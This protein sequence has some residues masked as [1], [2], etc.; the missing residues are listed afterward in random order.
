ML[1]LIWIVLKSTSFQF[2]SFKYFLLN[3]PINLNIFLSHSREGN[4]LLTFK[5]KP[6][7]VTC[8]ATLL[9][10]PLPPLSNPHPTKTNIPPGA[11]TKLNYKRET[12]FSTSFSSSFNTGSRSTF[13]FSSQ[14]LVCTVS[15]GHWVN[16][17]A[18]Q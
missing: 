5:T 3:L 15:P 1:N 7:I 10:F 18:T 2:H 12:N 9:H 16:E 14:V 6:S 13:E 17:A 8:Q 4:Y 11:K